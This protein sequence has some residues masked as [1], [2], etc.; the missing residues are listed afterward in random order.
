M[1]APTTKELAKH[2]AETVRVMKVL[3]T[4]LARFYPSAETD[5]FVAWSTRELDAIRALLEAE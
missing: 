4:K 5:D 2:L 1:P 3:C